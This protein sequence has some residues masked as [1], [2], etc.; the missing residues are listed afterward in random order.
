MIRLLKVLSLVAFVFLLNHAF[1]L[2]AA[3]P[4]N[5]ALHVTT[6]VGGFLLIGRLWRSIEHWV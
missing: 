5:L 4:L 2:L 1:A 3:T 6:S